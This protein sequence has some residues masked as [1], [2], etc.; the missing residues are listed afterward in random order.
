MPAIMC[1]YDVIII[2]RYYIEWFRVQRNP[3]PVARDPQPAISCSPKPL[4]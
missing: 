4:H 3:Q 1:K 2:S